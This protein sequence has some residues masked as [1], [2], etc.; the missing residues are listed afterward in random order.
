MDKPP[1]PHT[2]KISN[3]PEKFN[4]EE[5][6]EAAGGIGKFHSQTPMDGDSQLVVAEHKIIVAI[7]AQIL[8]QRELGY[9]GLHITTVLADATRDYVLLLAEFRYHDP[10]ETLNIAHYKGEEQTIKF[11]GAVQRELDKKLGQSANWQ[12]RPGYS[13]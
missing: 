8:L 3:K 5:I 2:E 7:A 10:G 9:E 4:P 6:R 11:V 1:R 12:Y 13:H